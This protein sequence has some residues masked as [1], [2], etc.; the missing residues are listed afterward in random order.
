M[1]RVL[2]Y[3]DSNTWGYISGSDHQRY[4]ENVRWTKLLQ[5]FLGSEYEVIEE[6]LNSRTLFSEDTRP[7]KEGRS[8][9]LYLKPCL[10]T[11]DKFDIFVLMLGTNELKT[12]YNN[13]PKDVL[14]MLQKFVDY[15]QNF[16]SQIDG[17]S[18]VLIVSGIPKIVTNEL[19]LQPDDKYFGAPAKSE[20]LSELYLDYCTKNNIPFIDNSNLEVGVDGLHITKEGHK[21]LAEK[22]YKKIKSL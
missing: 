13:T 2:C 1:I 9:F 8:G 10:E 18:P 19:N 4:N 12:T 22:I 3:G 6:G 14:I 5:K 16:K 20:E 7:G 11:H 17:S 21:K 15:I